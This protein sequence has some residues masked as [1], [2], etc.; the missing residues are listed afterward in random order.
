MATTKAKAS[1]RLVGVKAISRYLREQHDVA[2]TRTTLWKL[3]N[4]AGP[5]RFPADRMMYL[6]GFRVISETGNIDVWVRI[7]AVAPAETRKD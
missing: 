4:R 2:L 3:M 6:N 5:S 7:Y 1:R